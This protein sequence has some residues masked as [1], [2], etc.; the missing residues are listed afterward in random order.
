MRKFGLSIGINDYPGTGSDLHG[1]VND[2]MDWSSTLSR[3]GFEVA[4]LLDSAATKAKI[5]AGLEDLRRAARSGDIVVVTFSGH[6]SFTT[7]LDGDEEDGVDECW[8]PYDVHAHQITDDELHGIISRRRD[9]VKWILI[10]DSCHSGTIS[11]YAPITTPPTMSDADAP[12]RLI[13]FLPPSVF[14]QDEKQLD[15][16]TAMTR[17]P[18]RTT[19]PGRRTGLAMSGCQDQ[20]YSYDAWFNGRA[21]G[22]FTF[23]ALKALNDLPEG[24]S[25]ETWHRAIRN[26]LPSRQYAQ[27]PNLSGTSEAKAW[28][29]FRPQVA[30]YGPGGHSNQGTQVPGGGGERDAAEVG[31]AIARELLAERTEERSRSRVQRR[32][33]AIPVAAIGDSWFDYPRNDIK[34]LLEDAYGY[35]VESVADAGARV[36]DMAY[37]KGQLR[38]LIRTIE[39][40]A[41][42]QQAPRAVLL[43]GG[44]NDVAGDEFAELLNH[45]ESPNWGLNQASVDGAI[46]RI[47]D[48]YVSIISSIDEVMRRETG[49]VVPIVLHGYDYAV[50]DGRGVLGGWWFL[51]GPWLRPSFQKKGYRNEEEMHGIIRELIDALNEM[52]QELIRSMGLRHVHHVELRGELPTDGT[53]KEWWANELHPTQ[54]G[55]DIVARRFSLVLERA[56]RG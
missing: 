43:S 6:G 45:R 23:V 25:F 34:D 37:S 2:A 40:M 19:I 16:L 55:F 12:Q 20:E 27:T 24:A 5:L 53:Y 11:R 1:C 15:R 51:P 54:N 50:P 13:R 41:R 26:V 33:G 9:G 32:G 30:G 22:A 42:R 29:V 31:R 35:E 56:I 21:N 28:A 3:S 8:C 17:R 48:A 14:C 44:G 18:A 52:Q 36:E 49:Q 7:D 47:R 38:K 39:K 46:N 4:T 10:S